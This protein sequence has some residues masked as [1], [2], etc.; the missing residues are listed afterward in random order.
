MEVGWVVGGGVGGS[1]R[2]GGKK[3]FTFC[4]RQWLYPMAGEA[5]LESALSPSLP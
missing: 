3:E 2:R 1:M 5:S 4:R